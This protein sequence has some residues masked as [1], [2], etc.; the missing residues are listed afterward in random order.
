MTTKQERAERIAALNDELRKDPTKR[1][2]GFITMTQ[3]VAA[4]GPAFWV[5][6]IARLASLE[7]KDYDP[8]NDPHGERDFSVFE[9]DGHKCYGKI[10]YF[11][12]GGNF[13]AGAEHPENVETTDRVLTVMLREEY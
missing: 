3:G 2:L 13:T 12:R 11:E 5:K 10:D 1:H 7:P 4:L 8:G 9:V 6:V